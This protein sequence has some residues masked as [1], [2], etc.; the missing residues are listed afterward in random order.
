MGPSLVFR[1]TKQAIHPLTTQD[2]F[3]APQTASITV[4]NGTVRYI[5]A[6]QDYH[7]TAGCQECFCSDLQQAI[8]MHLKDQP[9]RV[10][11]I[12][13]QAVHIDQGQRLL[14]LFL[15][16]DLLLCKDS[17]ALDIQSL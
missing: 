6:P 11:R 12:G 3:K 17:S 15:C 7:M 14:L 1:V 5:H 9:L 13:T 8:E 2:F 10:P 16:E 4:V